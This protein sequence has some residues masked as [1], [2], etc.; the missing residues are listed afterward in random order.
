MSN[1]KYKCPSCGS[2]MLTNPSKDFVGREWSRCLSCGC[3]FQI[4]DYY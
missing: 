2:T 4:D 1:Y 3:A